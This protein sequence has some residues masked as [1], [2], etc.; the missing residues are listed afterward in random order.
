MSQRIDYDGR[1]FTRSD[2]LE[3]PTAVYRQRGDVLHGSFQG[4]DIRY[5]CL[6][7]VVREDGTLQFSYSMVD[8]ANQVISGQCTST[9]EVGPDNLVH[10]REEWQ[11]FSPVA[12]SGVSY[13]REIPDG[14]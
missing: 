6:C 10:L 12:C 14:T 13:L 11:R 3:A 4:A 1:R 7:G 2:V 5:G 8:A 9:A